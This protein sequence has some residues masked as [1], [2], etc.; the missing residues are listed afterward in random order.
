MYLYY[1]QEC[2]QGFEFSGKTSDGKRWMGMV[3]SRTMSTLV[4]ND[5]CLTWPIPDEW[6]LEEAATVPVVYGTVSVPSLIYYTRCID[7]IFFTSYFYCI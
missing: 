2:V 7:E 4:E 3:P 5:N 6:S 1:F